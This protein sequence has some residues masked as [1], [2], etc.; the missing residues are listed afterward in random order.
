[1]YL[2]RL[3]RINEDG[4]Y[5][6]KKE[7]ASNLEWVNAKRQRMLNR[8]YNILNERRSIHVTLQDVENVIEVLNRK[9]NGKRKFTFEIFERK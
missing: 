6:Y 8:W 4:I 5:T 9:D 2:L 3:R 7:T 1:M